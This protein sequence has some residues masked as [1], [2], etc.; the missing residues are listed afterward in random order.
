MLCFLI[1]GI[2]VREKDEVKLLEE[3]NVNVFYSLFYY[4]FKLNNWHSFYIFFVFIVL[5]KIYK[6]NAIILCNIIIL[7]FVIIS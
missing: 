4:F 6:N 5:A 1:K 3:E 7:L 2:V